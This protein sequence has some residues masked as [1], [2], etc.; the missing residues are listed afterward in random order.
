M[1][2]ELPSVALLIDY[3]NLEIGASYDM[4]GR[5]P[6]HPA[7]ERVAPPAGRARDAGPNRRSPGNRRRTAGTRAHRGGFTVR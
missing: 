1:R 2:R 4:P 6:E 5:A 3:D 7:P